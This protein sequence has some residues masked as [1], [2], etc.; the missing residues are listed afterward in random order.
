MVMQAEA[1]IKSVRILPRSK[2]HDIF[3]SLTLVQLKGVM[4]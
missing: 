4:E 2:I 3:N 1:F